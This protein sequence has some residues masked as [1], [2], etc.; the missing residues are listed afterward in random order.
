MVRLPEIELDDRGFQELVSEARTR[1]AQRCPEW[2]EHNV[3]DPG[4]HAHRAVRLDDRDD[5]VPAQPR[6]GQDLRPPARAARRAAAPADAGA[7]ERAL[8]AHRAAD[9]A[10]DDRGRR[11]RG[12]HGP[13]RLRGVRRLRGHREPHDRAAEPGGLRHPSRRPRARHPRRRRR[14]PPGRRRPRRLLRRPAA[15]RRDP[16]RLRRV[17]V[18][19]AASASTSTPTPR[20]APAST[21][22]ARRCAGRWAPARRRPASSSGSA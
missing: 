5:D 6:A 2:T 15:R 9:R 10:D 1:I 22:A 13:H 3:S 7:R 18:A 8:H 19:P 20:A 4:H 17:A 11:D 14:G 21:R 12:R 16:P